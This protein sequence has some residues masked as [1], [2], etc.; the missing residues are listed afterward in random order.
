LLAALWCQILKIDRVSRTDNFFALGG[1][2]ILATQLILAIARHRPDVVLSIRDI[3]EN[4]S[5][6][7]LARRIESTSLK[8]EH[9]FVAEQAIKPAPVGHPIPLSYSQQQMWFLN[10]YM[11]ANAAY[12]IAFAFEMPERVC[13]TTLSITLEQMLLR[14][15][16]LRTSF[17][18]HDGQPVQAIDKFPHSVTL[19]V[20][21]TDRAIAQIRR[22]ESAYRFDLAKDKL[23]RVRLVRSSESMRTLLL[24]TMHHS[25]SDGWSSSILFAEL[26]ELYSANLAQLPSPLQPLPIQFADYAYWQRKYLSKQQLEPQ[27]VYWRKQLKDLPQLLALPTD[28]PRPSEQTFSGSHC[29]V[30]LNEQLVRS[31]QKYC[32]DTETTVYM[33]LLACFSILLNRL[34]G[35]SD[36]VIGTPVANRSSQQVEKVIGFFVNTLVIRSRLHSNQ[37]FVKLLNETKEVVLQAHENQDVP[38]EMLVS[39]LNPERSLSYSPLFQVMFAMQNLPSQALHLG[40]DHVVNINV[41]EHASA[42]DLAKFSQFDL[43]LFVEQ[44]A[45]SCFARFEYNSDLFDASTMASLLGEFQNL[46]SVF[47]ADPYRQ[48]LNGASN[49]SPETSLADAGEADGV[50]NAKLAKTVA[51]PH[52]EIERALSDVWKNLLYVKEVSRDDNFFHLGGHSLLITQLTTRIRSVFNCDIPIKALFKNTTIQEQAAL[53]EQYQASYEPSL[54]VI[55]P[56]SSNAAV[57]L[58]LPQ[59]RLWFMHQYIGPNSVYNIS[60]AVKIS[61][62]L[63]NVALCGSLENIFERHQ[64]LRTCYRQV[65]DNVFQVVKDYSPQ[66]AVETIDDESSLFKV[67]KLE[68]R[69]K[70][71]LASDALCRVRCVRDARSNC[72]WLIVTMHHSISDGWSFEVFFRD[73]RAIYEVLTKASGSPLKPLPLQFADFAVWQNRRMSKERL[74]KQLNYWRDALAGLPLL[75]TL[76][77]DNQRPTKQTFNGAIKSIQ[78]PPRLISKVEGLCRAFDVTLFMNLLASFSILLSRYSRQSDIAIGTP[79]ANRTALETENVIGFFAN[80]LVMRCVVAEEQTFAE[81]LANTRLMALQGYEHQDVPFGMLVEELN[82]PRSLGYSP[83]FQVMFALQN[84]PSE[85]LAVDGVAFEQVDLDRHFERH[86]FKGEGVSHHDLTFVVQQRNQETTGLLEY[87]CDLFEPDT[88]EELLNNFLVLLEQVTINPDEKI[89]NVRWTSE[90]DITRQL[91]HWNDTAFSYDQSQVIHE[92]FEEQVVRTPGACAIVCQAERISYSVLNQK[93]NQ[94]AHYLLSKGVKPDSMVGLCMTRSIDL[95]VG[96]LG[97]LKSGAAYVPLDPNYPRQRLDYILKD[98]NVDLVVTESS[99]AT[100]FDVQQKRVLLLDKDTD[101]QQQEAAVSSQPVVNPV[102]AQLGLMPHHL[103][104]IIYT[105]GSTGQPKGVLIEHRNTVSFLHWAKSEFSA[106]ETQRMLASTT[107]CFDLSIFEIFLPLITGGQMVL[108]NSILDLLGNKQAYDISLINTVPSAINELAKHDSIPESVIT[109]NLAGEALR[110]NIVDAIRRH[111]RVRYV[112][113]LYG[114]SEY[115]TYA[116]NARVS[117]ESQSEPDIG[118]AIFNT[119]LYVLDNQLKPV[120]RGVVGELYISGL[121]LARGYHNREDITNAKFIAHPFI[122]EVGARCYKT[123]DLVRWQTD[124]TLAFLGRIDDQVKIRGFRIELGE[125]EAKLTQLELVEKAVVVV[126]NFGED[127]VRLV[128][129]LEPVNPGQAHQEIIEHCRGE[130]QQTLPSHMV[131]GVFVVM[132]SLPLTANGKLD[133]KQLPM[134][135]EAQCSTGGEAPVGELEVLLAALWCQILKIDRVSRTDNFF[136]L[137]GH[138]LLIIKMLSLLDDNGITTD[139]SSILG[140][141]NLSEMAQ[142]I[143]RSTAQDNDIIVPPNLI[144]A[145]NDTLTP[146][147]VTMVDLDQSEINAIVEATEGGVENIADIYPLTP[148]QEGMLF[149]SLLKDDIDPYILRRWYRVETRQRLEEIFTAFQGLVDRHDVLR[150]AIASKGVNVPVQVVHKHATLSID[151]HT[152]PEHLSETERVSA[153]SS[154]MSPLEVSRAPLLRLGVAELAESAASLLLVEAHHTIV[155]HMALAMLWEEVEAFLLGRQDSLPKPRSFREFVAK[156]RYRNAQANSEHYFTQQLS[157]ITEPTAP[158]GY[159]DVLGDGRDIREDTRDIPSLLSSEIRQVSRQLK[160]SP[161]ALFHAAFAMVISACSDRADVVFG[162]VLFGRMLG[163]KGIERMLGPFINTLPVRLS[164][165][166]KTAKVLL[167]EADQ[168]LR[169]LLPHEQA[170]LSLAQKCSAVSSGNPLFTALLNYRHVDAEQDNA[171]DLGDRRGIG[172]YH[173][174]GEHERSNYPFTVSINDDGKWFVVDTLLHH[175]IDSERVIGYLIKSLHVLLHDLKSQNV[176]DDVLTRS[177]IP[178]A[179]MQILLPQNVAPLA[180]RTYDLSSISVYRA[181]AQASPDR[182]AL[183]IQG[184]KVTYR[185]L[186]RRLQHLI[187][188]LRRA[189]VEKDLV[190]AIRT[191]DVVDAVCGLLA[192]SA[193]GATCLPIKATYDV[194]AVEFLLKDAQASWFLSGS[195]HFKVDLPEHCRPICVAQQETEQYEEGVTF[196]ERALA[197]HVVAESLSMLLYPSRNNGTPQGLR[198]SFSQHADLVRTVFHVGEHNDQGKLLPYGLRDLKDSNL[199]VVLQLWR[200]ETFSD[201]TVDSDLIAQVDGPICNPTPLLILDRLLRPAPLDVLGDVFVQGDF[202][203]DIHRGAVSQSHSLILNKRMANGREVTLLRTNRKGKRRAKDRVDLAAGSLLD[204]R[205]ICLGIKQAIQNGHAAKSVHVMH[206]RT[207]HFGNADI[208]VYLVPDNSDLSAQAAENLLSRINSTLRLLPWLSALPSKLVLMHSLP[209]GTDG[210]VSERDLLLVGTETRPFIAPS[211]GVEKAVCDIWQTVFE[212]ER[213]SMNDHFFSLGGQSLMATRL[214]SAIRHQFSIELSISLLFEH[215]TVQAFSDEI[216]ARIA[217]AGLRPLQR[218]ISESENFEE[219]LL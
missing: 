150:T 125:I 95:I 49:S 202:C 165:R 153:L 121:G 214:V 124:G 59:K 134:P 71:D 52:G 90:S 18:E 37:N 9:R 159:V 24:V 189:G 183:D 3:L 129:Y 210:E 154:A 25:V 29:S 179:E 151:F 205:Q 54:D 58:S 55:E 65:G 60:S 36:I 212:L 155:D 104:Y 181:V 107:I 148:L 78:F 48:V 182:T 213:V 135:T 164:L 215:S 169:E 15:T 188:L 176:V 147:M 72:V 218:E 4:N 141:L 20:H 99:L 167:L 7:S 10:Q 171:A 199:D 22:Q 136:A 187:A 2:S 64:I 19:E 110:R 207:D 100:M 132:E 91:H 80:T 217:V 73:L 96:M 145:A 14:H 174:L 177:V 126:R 120:P 46:L 30:E 83:L 81:H 42:A 47:L 161:A 178:D 185:A 193:V 162:T 168:A 175:E 130:L 196:E 170:S 77:T 85:E 208:V 92:L 23:C 57:P 156:S 32:N 106:E 109:V 5:I 204:D 28:R 89:K 194:T 50:R 12:N 190:I 163:G 216:T 113:N 152:L 206:K 21:G 149:H 127:D 172:G 45:D 66:V 86:G 98:A 219:V 11:G 140:A 158:F 1:H 119:Q 114:P 111:S 33:Y 138:S 142:R 84:M 39:E 146:A 123:G 93:A 103:A 192:T 143:T 118:K 115:T 117:L 70:F 139:V 197:P 53:I 6:E 13:V 63:D 43:S 97:I 195:I 51:P 144:L 35:Q 40:S 201:R 200:G 67:W 160:I 56:T 133:K 16:A 101:S 116:T 180:G 122:N 94:V 186:N 105:S 87:N 131:P 74:S 31:I 75:I 38:L 26:A 68:S 128:A 211:T 203:F 79:I 191:E 198:F 62:D 102:K 76:P 82:P 173:L 166:G 27:L 184:V 157:D 61:G 108:V 17:A 44:T 34:S 8:S 209:V 88:M 137:G 41:A 69:Y 112:N